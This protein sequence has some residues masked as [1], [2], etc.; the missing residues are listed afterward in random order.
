MTSLG[1]PAFYLPQMDPTQP[2][3]PTTASLPIHCTP[4]NLLRTKRRVV[5]ICNRAYEDLAIWSYRVLAK[6]GGVEVGSAVAFIR[7][8][9]LRAEKAALRTK[10]SVEDEMPGVVLLNTGQLLYSYK[11]RSALSPVSWDALP[12][13]SLLHPAPRI[14]DKWNRIEGNE[15]IKEHVEF[16]FGRIVGNEDFVQRDADVYVVG[17]HDGGEEVTKYLNSKCESI[18]QPSR[19]SS[20]RTLT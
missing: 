12:R 18:A 2:D 5:V 9:R 14:D 19:I 17:I 10:R 4:P 8:M 20:C 7:E 6:A 11:K 1:V 3:P 16:V 15:S 13:K